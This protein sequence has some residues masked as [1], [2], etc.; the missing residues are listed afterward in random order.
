[1]SETHYSLKEMETPRDFQECITLQLLVRNPLLSE[2]DGNCQG[3]EAILQRPIT[4]SETHYSL[5]EME[6][7]SLLLAEKRIHPRRKLT[8]L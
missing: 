1:M 5:K 7:S 8:T 6:T 2:R 3:Y 4:R